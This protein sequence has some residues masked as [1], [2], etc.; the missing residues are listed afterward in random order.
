MVLGSKLRFDDNPLFDQPTAYRSLIAALQYLTMTRPDLSFAMNKLSQF[1]KAPIVNHW[2]ACKHV[3]H[4]IQGT[5]HHGL[6]FRQGSTLQLKGYVDVDWASSLS[7]R[8]STSSYCIFLGSNLGQWSSKKHQ[9][10][11]LSSTKA[12]YRALPQASIEIIWLQNLF[13]ELH[14]SIP[15][16]PVL[17]CDNTSAGALAFDPIFHARTKHIEIDVHFVQE[18]V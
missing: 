5:L 17:W 7:H 3:L 13:Q 18:M 9:V 14:V 8:K 6:T 1:L 12:E 11:A 4:Y 2:H 15:G 10:V 16:I